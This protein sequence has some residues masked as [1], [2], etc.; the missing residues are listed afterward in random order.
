MICSWTTRLKT[1]LGLG[2]ELVKDDLQLDHP[3]EDL[4]KRSERSERS[5][6]SERS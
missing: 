2:L 1:W 6:G 3:L 4:G 5:E